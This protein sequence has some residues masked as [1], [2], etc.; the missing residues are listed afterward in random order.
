MPE[1]ESSFIHRLANR[2]HTVTSKHCAFRPFPPSSGAI[3]NGMLQPEQKLVYLGYALFTSAGRD[4]DLHWQYLFYIIYGLGKTHPSHHTTLGTALIKRVAAAAAAAGLTSAAEAEQAVRLPVCYIPNRAANAT[5]A[6]PDGGGT[7]ATAS[8]HGG[9]T[10]RPGHSRHQSIALAHPS[11][12][13]FSAAGFRPDAPGFHSGVNP[14][15]RA[16]DQ[17]QRGFRGHKKRHMAALAGSPLNPRTVAGEGFS[18][19]GGV[20]NPSLV[21]A[22]G[23]G[24][25]Q[26][27]N[28]SHVGGGAAAA[29]HA[30]RHSRKLSNIAE[31]LLLGQ[32]GSLAGA[33]NSSSSRPFGTTATTAAA[34]GGGGGA[35]GGLIGGYSSSLNATSGFGRA[36]SLHGWGAEVMPVAT[37]VQ[38]G[39]RGFALGPV[40][41]SAAAAAAARAA[42]FRQLPL[43]IGPFP[44]SA[45]Q[46]SSAGGGAGGGSSVMQGG[47]AARGAA[48]GAGSSS[49]IKAGAAAGAGSSSSTR[50]AGAGSSSNITAETAAGAA[51]ASGTAKAADGSGSSSS[52][53]D[54]GAVL[55]MRS[56]LCYHLQTSLV[57]DAEVRVTDLMIPTGGNT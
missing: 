22:P 49:S 57:Y 54:E 56:H 25:R 44:L 45:E 48:P 43:G 50:A 11:L 13:L 15:A 34:G 33:I 32:Q 5:A 51:A 38:G 24:L 1:G 35:G 52:G 2:E 3:N 40:P 20:Q 30:K 36:P 14:G 27:G 12:S 29:A 28:S 17:G 53:S 47:T 19:Q 42:A 41:E 6:A 9:I 46:S 18:L 55:L 26:L 37:E 31:Q 7:A 39:S 21:G 16:H 23:A 4:D 8:L 10:P